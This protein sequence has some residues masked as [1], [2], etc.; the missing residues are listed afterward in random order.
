[1]KNY[2]LIPSGEGAGRDSRGGCPTQI[3]I[4][5]LRLKAE[6]HTKKRE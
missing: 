2:G 3:S 4:A 5:W 1:M 6:Q